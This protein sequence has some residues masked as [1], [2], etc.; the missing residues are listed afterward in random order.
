MRASGW[1]VCGVLVMGAGCATTGQPAV[2]PPTVRMELADTPATQPLAER[3]DR[4]YIDPELGFE[5]SRPSGAW[6]LDAADHQSEE[7]LMIPVVMRHLDSGAQV[8]VQIAPAVA[9]PSQFAERLTQGLRTQPGFLSGDPEPLALSDDAVGFDF[10][11]SDK[12]HGKVAVLGGKN[13]QVFLMLAT[14]PKD[15]PQS[16]PEHVQAIFQSLRPLPAATAQVLP[17]AELSL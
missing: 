2:A 7:G 15:A 5:I 12:V 9:T 4:R 13:G 3:S 17:P 8:V 14:W 11:L 16:V 1:A 10:T 6:E